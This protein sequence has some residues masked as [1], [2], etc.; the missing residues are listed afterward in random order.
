MVFVVRN[1]DAKIL[2]IELKFE[3]RMSENKKNPKFK[4]CKVSISDREVARVAYI[5]IY[6]M[7]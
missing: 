5:Y 4:H 2:E 3:N 1:P 7:V 6:L